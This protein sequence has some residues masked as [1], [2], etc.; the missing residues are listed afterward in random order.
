MK[1]VFSGLMIAGFAVAAFAGVAHA[2][3]SKAVQQ[4]CRSDYKKLC[5]DYGL[6]SSGLRSCMNR[7]GKNLSKSCVRALVK[8]GH[9]SQAEVN[10]RK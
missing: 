7:N 1:S 4:Y 9:V 3:Y 2:G 5:G 8:G 6:E 10:R